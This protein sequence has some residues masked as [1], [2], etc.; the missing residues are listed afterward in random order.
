MPISRIGL[1]GI[2]VKSTH[3]AYA[4]I[5]SVR[6]KQNKLMDPSSCLCKLR[7]NKEDVPK[8]ADRLLGVPVFERSCCQSVRWRSA[9]WSA[10]ERE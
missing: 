10:F 6:A 7:G 4:H 3:L 8:A 2:P 9:Y 1:S 5:G